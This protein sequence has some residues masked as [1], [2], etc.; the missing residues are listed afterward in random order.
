[1]TTLTLPALPTSLIPAIV[2]PPPAAAAPAAAAPAAPVVEEKHEEI[3]DDADVKMDPIDDDDDL[4]VGVGHASEETIAAKID[5]VD[6]AEMEDS[7]SPPPTAEMLQNTL[8]LKQLKD[9]CNELGLNA[10][11]KKMELAERIV[12]ATTA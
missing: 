5:L 7:P 8:S 4:I 9:R 11:G 10:T 3:L 6:D 2:A 12:S 1:M